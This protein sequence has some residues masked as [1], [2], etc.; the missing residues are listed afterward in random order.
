[1]NEPPVHFT[2][3]F[4]WNFRTISEE[5]IHWARKRR[6]FRKYAMGIFYKLKTAKPA[7]V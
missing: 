4:Y 2:V 3:G 1:M 5:Y 6:K 7:R